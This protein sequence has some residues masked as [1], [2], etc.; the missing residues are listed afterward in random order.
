MEVSSEG[1]GIGSLRSDVTPGGDNNGHGRVG[2]TQDNGMYHKHWACPFGTHN[3]TLCLPQRERKK[4][5]NGLFSE[6]LRLKSIHPLCNNKIN[7][8]FAKDK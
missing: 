4:I 5:S 7:S 2:Q 1:N 8:S 6:H 3:Y